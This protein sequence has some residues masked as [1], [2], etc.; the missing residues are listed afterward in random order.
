MSS[1]EVKTFTQ[2][3][4]ITNIE[5]DVFFE[6]QFHFSDTL[7]VLGTLKGEVKS[8]NGTISIEPEGLIDGIIKSHIIDNQGTLKGEAYVDQYNLLSSGKS[9]CNIISKT[10]SVEKGAFISGKLNME[11]K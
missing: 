8:D 10:I 2:N 1:K 3:Q 6:G 7:T 9:Q 11:D 5:K 4:Q